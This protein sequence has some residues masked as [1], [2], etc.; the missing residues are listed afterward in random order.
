MHCGPPRKP[1]RRVSRQ[2]CR[3]VVSEDA[4]SSGLFSAGPL[5]RLHKRRAAIVWEENAY[6]PLK[7][8]NSNVP[9]L[10]IRTPCVYNHTATVGWRPLRGRR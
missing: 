2:A 8:R 9:E 6:Q 7:A 1:R 3:Y 5:L 10:T 4:I